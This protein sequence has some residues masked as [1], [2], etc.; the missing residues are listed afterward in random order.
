VFFASVATGLS[1]I[2]GVS[3]AEVRPL[4][5]S[6]LIQ[7][8][9]PVARIGIAAEQA[10][11]FVLANAHAPPK[12]TP[13]IAISPRLVAAAG[14]GVLTLWQLAQGQVLPPALT[15]GWYAASLGGLLSNGD[16]AEG[17]E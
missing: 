5:G 13:T 15:L 10:R 9:G 11:L 4:T 1:A 6:I 2:P 12:P 8:A 16:S 3:R 17:A 7:H 14:L